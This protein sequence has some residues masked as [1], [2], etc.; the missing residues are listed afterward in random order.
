[1][2]QVPEF[3]RVLVRSGI[4]IFKYWLSVSREDAEYRAG[5]LW[6]RGFSAHLCMP[7]VIFC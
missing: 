7:G 3:E 4:Q 5:S 6:R 1:M 2:R